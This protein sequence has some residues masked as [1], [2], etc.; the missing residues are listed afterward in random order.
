VC[1]WTAEGGKPFQSAKHVEVN[2]LDGEIIWAGQDEGHGYIY[3]DY[4]I[5]KVRPR[6][7]GGSPLRRLE[8][9]NPTGGKP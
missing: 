7:P 4:P 2:C 1:V 6:L 5:D 3:K 8:S 9:T